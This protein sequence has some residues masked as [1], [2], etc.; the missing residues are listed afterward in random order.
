MALLVAALRTQGAY[1]FPASSLFAGFGGSVFS[2]CQK[3]ST[4]VCLLPWRGSMP[5]QGVAALLH[6]T[7]RVDST[8]AVRWYHLHTT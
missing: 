1:G 8:G 3:V 2:K 5:G 4:H 6:A 7:S